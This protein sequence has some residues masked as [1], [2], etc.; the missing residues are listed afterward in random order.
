MYGYDYWS[1][2]PESNS[3][4]YSTAR[5]FY[6]ADDENGYVSRENYNRDFDTIIRCFKNSI[7]IPQIFTIT[8]EASDNN[9]ETSQPAVEQVSGSVIKLFTGTYQA[10]KD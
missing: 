1:S 10:T 2:S 3:I 7:S 5:G 9:G 8:F 4:Y 6:V